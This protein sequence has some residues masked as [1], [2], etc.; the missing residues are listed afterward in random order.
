MTD[1]VGRLFGNSRQNSESDDSDNVGDYSDPIG[2]STPQV[3]MATTLLD[4]AAQHKVRSAAF[5]RQ[6]TDLEKLL[7]ASPPDLT[8][9]R[10]ALKP[11]ESV[12]TIRRPYR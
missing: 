9:I 3:T 5:S 12:R 2:E 10:G 11:N 8:K 7:K 4:I 6:M 1:L